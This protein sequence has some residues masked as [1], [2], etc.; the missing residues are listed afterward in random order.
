M[1]KIETLRKDSTI[2]NATIA[3][4]NAT[5]TEN[6][7]RDVEAN[8]RT[9]QNLQGSLTGVTPL[10]QREVLANNTTTATAAK[11]P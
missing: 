1:D 7:L 3:Q 5:D 6:M 4:S 9:F 11:M 8:H 2:F 10:A